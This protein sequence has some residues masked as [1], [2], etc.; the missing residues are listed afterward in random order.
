[1]LG[2][3]VRQVEDW[4][5]QARIDVAT[6]YRSLALRK[7]TIIGV[8]GSGGKT[9]AKAMMAAILR[10]RFRITH[11]VGNLNSAWHLAHTVLT[12]RPWHDACVLE[13]NAGPLGAFDAS[14]AMARPDIAVVTAVGTDHLSMY[15]SIDGVAEVKGRLVS[16]LS[17][18][19]T[20]LL[21]ADDPRVLAMRSRCAGRVVTYGI[22][23]DADYRAEAIQSAWPDRMSFTA[24]AGDRRVRVQTQLCGGHWV[25]SVLASLA[26]G[27]LLGV[28][29]G[30][31]A[32]AVATVPPFPGRLS[33]GVM[34]DGVTFVRDDQKA[35]I[36]AFPAFFDFVRS[37]RARRTIVVLGTLSDYP[38]DARRAYRGVGMQALEA[39]DL[40][41][42]V[43]RQAT[44]YLKARR[45]SD[46][47]TMRIARDVQEAIDLLRGIVRPGD[48]VV[49]KGSR[50]T[51]DLHRIVESWTSASEES[52]ARPERA[53]RR[54]MTPHD[55]QVVIG[56]GNPGLSRR[57]T[58]HNV[59]Y[60]VLDRL[61]HAAGEAWKS[62]NAA[63]IVRIRRPGESLM[64][65]KLETPINFSGERLTQLASLYDFRPEDC[66]VVLDDLHLSPGTV[67]YREGGSAG[68]HNGMQSI[69]L[70]FQTDRIAR[71]KVGIGQPPPGQRPADFL[72]APFDETHRPLME[73]AIADAASRTMDF[74]DRR[75]RGRR[76]DQRDAASSERAA[77]S[78]ARP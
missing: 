72:L 9:T 6:Q 3:L 65:L 32:R 20:A 51:D 29:L 47:A 54:M 35:P 18:G 74:V 14:I 16:A 11:S 50:R 45:E 37:A 44:H 76:S 66:I 39:A 71:V 69:L 21:N 28:P 46:G 15:G 25:T 52:A 78:G 26:L 55:V 43:G 7:P 56:L 12:T 70:A 62:E 31:A 49:T 33:P 63:R 73:Q 42:G 2:R 34:P 22:A 13:F 60:E 30:D 64:L 38:G 58:P 77:L 41:I 24:V 36:W 75:S 8:T 53:P 57:G 1:M 5:R 19:G 4:K 40:V 17:G 59:G 23:R 48:L 67:R 10:T 68:G 27:D 61:A